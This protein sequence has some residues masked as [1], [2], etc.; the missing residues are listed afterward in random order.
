MKLNKYQ[1]KFIKRVLD[2]AEKSNKEKRTENTRNAFFISGLQEKERTQ[3]L[4]TH[5]H[6]F[7]YE[8]GIKEFVEYL[9]RGKEP[10][11]NDVIYCEGTKNN[12]YVEVSFQ[13]NDS[14]NDSTFSFDR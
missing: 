13:H 8:G 1:E 7:M 11:Y 12:V 4:S 14:F 10:I 5:H 9:N 2:H 6:E 3:F